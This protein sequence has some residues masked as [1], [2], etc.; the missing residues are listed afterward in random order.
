M[1]LQALL[2]SGP[3]ILDL[4]IVAAYII[5]ISA[6]IFG[7]YDIIHKK[8]KRDL[9][10]MAITLAT[11]AALLGICELLKNGSLTSNAMLFA[12]TYDIIAI[13]FTIQ[14]YKNPHLTNEQQKQ[15]NYLKKFINTIKGGEK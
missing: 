7:F 1:T 10:T 4:I 3:F 13:Y 12:Y 9:P 11:S 2:N 15:T 8:W 14:Y 6:T 5:G